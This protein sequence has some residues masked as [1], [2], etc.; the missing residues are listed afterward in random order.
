MNFFKSNQLIGNKNDNQILV[1]WGRL[2]IS[3]FLAY[4]KKQLDNWK[5]INYKFIDLLVISEATA[6]KKKICLK[7]SQ[8]GNKDREGVKI[9]KTTKLTSIR[10][11]KWNQKN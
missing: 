8:R 5:M 7:K 6:A 3:F 1:Y 11:E 9:I 10:T 4:W 2:S